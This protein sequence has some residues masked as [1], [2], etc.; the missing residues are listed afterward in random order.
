MDRRPLTAVLAGAVVISFSAILFK[1][2]GAD[3][4]TGG[5]FRMAYAFPVLA[6]LAWRRRAEDGRRPRDRRLAVLSGAFLG[7]DVIAW[8]T[9]IGYVGAGLSTLIANSQVV[10]V[11]FLTW[12]ILRE[13]PSR[14][15]LTSLPIVGAGLVLLTGLGGDDTYG[16]RPALGVV[17]A[18]LAALLYSGFLITFRRSN[19]AQVPQAGPLFESVAGAI[20]LIAVAGILQGR[21]DLAPTWPEHGWLLLLA[22]GPQVVGWLLIAYGLPRLPATTTS[23]AVV[24]QPT[25]TLLWGATLLGEIPSPVQ[26]VGGA[27][28]LAAIARA[29][30]GS[31]DVPRSAA[32][33]GT[34]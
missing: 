23:F 25:L 21:L 29:T 3:P 22:L 26:I 28:V 4:H 30:L 8:Q 5:F 34:G 15:A 11:P 16:P 14:R 19:Q 31:R 13:R 20:G 10:M 7:A 18:L 2:S 33:A 24:L 17:V 32:V 1:V 27:L 9:A 12:M 6:A